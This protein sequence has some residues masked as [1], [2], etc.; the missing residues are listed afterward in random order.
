M[1]NAV[2]NHIHLAPTLGSS[3]ENAPIW[4]WKA[5]NREAVIAFRAEIVETLGGM[6]FGHVATYNDA[7][8]V[9]RDFIY[10]IKL[11]D[12]EDGD[13]FF[14]IDRLASMGGKYVYLVDHYH[15]ADASDH[16]AN[17]RQMFVYEIGSVPPEEPGLGFFYVKVHLKD[18]EPLS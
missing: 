17:V 16:T 5:R 15:A 6:R 9:R 11:E 1:A 18:M 10:E 2:R 4:K 7:P 3:P 12:G 13:V 14:Y 8:V